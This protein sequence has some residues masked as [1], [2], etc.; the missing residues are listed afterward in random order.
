MWRFILAVLPLV[1]GAWLG[2]AAMRHRAYLRFLLVAL[3]AGAAGI[4]P[5]L[6][7]LFD[8]PVRLCGSSDC[9]V[10]GGIFYVAGLGC[11]F[12]VIGWLAGGISG[13]VI[14]RRERAAQ[15]ASE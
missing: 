1:L 5:A 10:A 15:R 11:L 8:Y 6:Y 12:F 9:G 13:L 3:A 7:I 2:M 4:G 14:N